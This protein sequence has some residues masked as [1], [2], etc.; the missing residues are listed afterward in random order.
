VRDPVFQQ[1]LYAVEGIY[2]GT[3]VDKLT[4]EGLYIALGNTPEGFETCAKV[5]SFSI[6]K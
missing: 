1:C 5:G 4:N 3:V 2:S 6:Y